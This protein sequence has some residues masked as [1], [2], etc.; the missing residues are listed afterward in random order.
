MRTW[1]NPARRANA[2]LPTPAAKTT[3]R[4]R[5]SASGVAIASMPSGPQRSALGATSV[6]TIRSRRGAAKQRTSCGTSTTKSSISMTA[7]RWKGVFLASIRRHC[8]AANRLPNSSRTRA[9]GSGANRCMC[10]ASTGTLRKSTSP[11]PAKHARHRAGMAARPR[12]AD[13]ASPPRAYFRPPWTMPWEAAVCA[14]PTA[15]ASQMAKAMPRWASRLPSQR[16][17]M[18]APTMATSTSMRSID[19]RRYE[20][21][22]K[23]LLPERSTP[24]IR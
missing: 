15:S 5:T 6:A 8:P 17:A 19:V 2:S 16:P 14:P 3:C 4:A 12:E 18:P 9:L 7:P 22:R 23:S 1:A 11:C 21:I 24:R 10:S 20:R 13:V